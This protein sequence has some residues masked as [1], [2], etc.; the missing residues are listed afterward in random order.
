[1]KEELRKS[2]EREKHYR[3]ALKEIKYIS[4]HSNKKDERLEMIQRVTTV[5][6]NTFK[7][8]A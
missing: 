3:E 1:M 2:K 8:Q 7:E 4:S 6:L 5:A